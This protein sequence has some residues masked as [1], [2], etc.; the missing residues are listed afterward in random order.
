MYQIEIDSFSGPL[1]LLL[2]LISKQKMSIEEIPLAAITDQYLSYINFMQQLDMEIATE[3]IVTASILIFIK[4]KTL[5]PRPADPSEDLD[6]EEE[7]RQRLIEYKKIKEAALLLSDREQQYAGIYSKLPEEIAVD[8]SEIEFNQVPP[9]AL[10]EAFGKILLQKPFAAPEKS[11]MKLKRDA[12]TINQAIDCL[13]YALL[14]TESIY[15]EEIFLN[16]ETKNEI[17]TL[18]MGLLELL[19]DNVLTARQE[20]TYAPIKLMRGTAWMKENK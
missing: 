16:Y 9:S 17:I 13:K 4:S 18:F 20:D 19:K 15:F 11:T 6:P 5:L 7:L 8:V 1:D 14:D 2:E 12:M 10:A 3:F